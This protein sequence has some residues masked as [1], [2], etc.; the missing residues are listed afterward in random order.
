MS[1]WYNPSPFFPSQGDGV[2]LRRPPCAW[3]QWYRVL[4]AEEDVHHAVVR[5][6]A[7]DHTGAPERPLP[8][9]DTASSHRTKTVQRCV[10]SRV[11]TSPPP[12]APHH[13]VMVGA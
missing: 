13:N 9:R 4:Y 3:N 7:Q 8:R 1:P 11:W 6:P 2:V 5:T 10:P 12:F